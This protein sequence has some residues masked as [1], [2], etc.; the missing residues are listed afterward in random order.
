MVVLTYC[1]GNYQSQRETPI[2]GP[3]QLGNPLTDFETGETAKQVAECIFPI[4]ILFGAHILS[5]HE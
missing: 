3:S 4:L 5:F 1:K 2:F